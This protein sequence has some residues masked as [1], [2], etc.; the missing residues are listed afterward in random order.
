MPTRSIVT[1]GPIDLARTTFP[2]RRGTADPT[3]RIGPGDVWRATR[4]PEG[5]A[6]LHLWM[7]P[8]EGRIEAA[9]WGPGA[10]WA[11][12]HA[13]GLAGATDDDR[14]FIAHHDL[15]RELHRRLRGVRLTRTDRMTETLIPAVL[16]QKVT[17][18]Q[19]RRA[20]A[21]MTRALSEPAPST[22]GEGVGGLLLPPDPGRVASL[23][24]H[25]FHPFGLERRR[26][27][28]LRAL[29]A[30]ADPIDALAELPLETARERL[31]AHRGVGVWTAAEV[32]RL[33]LGDPDALSVGDYHLK[34]LVS[35]ALAGEPR[36][37]DER[38]LELLEPYRG[39]RG[40]VQRLLEASGI[41]APRF[42]PRADVRSI[43]RI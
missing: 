32:G 38:M 9:A 6:T 4:T 41:G 29:C 40:R 14:G 34:H 1:P 43:E 23:P 8:S 7:Q 35:W 27:E 24:Y 18:M 36:G 19:A 10:A 25:D 30:R 17:G 26:A 33:A 20:Y 15:I 5:P 42:G 39:H 37:T 22:S 3:M 31:T 2:L 11:L 13:P 21:R 16:E 28:V 12:D